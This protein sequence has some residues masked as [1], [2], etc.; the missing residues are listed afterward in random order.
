LALEVLVLAILT[1]DQMTDLL[2]RLQQAQM[3]PMLSDKILVAPD[4]ELEYHL[5]Q[6]HPPALGGPLHPFQGAGQ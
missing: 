4:H 1:L 2:L 3:V 5:S 6:A